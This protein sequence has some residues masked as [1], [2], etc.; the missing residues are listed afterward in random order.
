MICFVWV[1]FG[2]LFC[3]FLFGFFLMFKWKILNFNRNE[4]KNCFHCFFLC[5]WAMPRSL[6]LPYYL[7]S[8]IYT[9]LYDLSELS[10]PGWTVP[11][12]SISS[13]DRCF[14]PLIIFVAC[15]FLLYL[16]QYIHVSIVLRSPV[17]DSALQ[18]CFTGA[19]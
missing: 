1:G 15:G 10:S 5:H 17:L 2:F 8:N 19:D 6:H 13:Y 7:P 12:L 16:L 4:K 14:S 3:W 11:A 9:Y 18:I